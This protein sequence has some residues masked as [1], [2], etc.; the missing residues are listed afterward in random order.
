MPVGGGPFLSLR[1]WA[2]TL[3]HVTS[4]DILRKDCHRQVFWDLCQP[5]RHRAP[6]GDTPPLPRPLPSRRQQP[7][8]CRHSRKWAAGLGAQGKLLEGKWKSFLISIWTLLVPRSNRRLQVWPHVR[9]GPVPVNQE[10]CPRQR[11]GSEG[12]EDPCPASWEL[13]ALEVKPV[14]GRKGPATCRTEQGPGSPADR[15][16]D[17]GSAQRVPGRRAVQAQGQSE[18]RPGG[19]TRPS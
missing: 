18:R 6:L 7:G 13:G 1:S 14:R 15:E 3:S 17:K 5:D 2:F 9:L 8:P 12:L 10:P 19:R 16:T 4:T 11:V